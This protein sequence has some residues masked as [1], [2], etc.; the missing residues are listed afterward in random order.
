MVVMVCSRVVKVL[1]RLVSIFDM[2]MPLSM[3]KRDLSKVPPPRY[4]TFLVQSIGNN[5]T[6]SS[7][8]I[9]EDRRSCDKGR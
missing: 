2:F 6:S 7:D 4:T 3:Q 1:S 8:N 5:N 9:R